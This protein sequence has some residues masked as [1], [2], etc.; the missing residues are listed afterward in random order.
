MLSGIHLNLKLN[1]LFVVVLVLE[2]KGLY[3]RIDKVLRKRRTFSLPGREMTFVLNPRP[4]VTV[5]VIM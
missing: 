5:L 3:S 1:F 4:R 2:Y